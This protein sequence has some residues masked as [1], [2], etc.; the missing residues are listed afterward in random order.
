LGLTGNALEA[1]L[2]SIASRYHDSYGYEPAKAA[3]FSHV[4]NHGGQLRCV[5]SGEYYSHPYEPNPDDHTKTNENVFNC[6]HT[7]PQSMGINSTAKADLHHLFPTFSTINSKRG[8]NPFGEVSG[9][10]TF[11]STTYYSALAGGVF[12]PADQHKGNVARAMLYMMVR[13]DNPSGFIDD[14]NQFTTFRSWHQLD[15][16]DEAERTRNDLVEDYQLNRNPFIDCPQFVEALY[17]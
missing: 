13:Y 6:E 16:V 9:G 4:D 15:P 11:G 1:A 2:K 8:N 12:E 10:E 3:M 7:W 17:Q 14:N 5:Y